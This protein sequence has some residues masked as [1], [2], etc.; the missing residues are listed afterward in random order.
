[1][2]SNETAS[3]FYHRL[4]E[5]FKH[6]YGHRLKFGDHHFT[7]MSK[8]DFY[9][10]KF[11]IFESEKVFFI[12]SITKII[13]NLKSEKYIEE[14]RRKISDEKTFSSPFYGTGMLDEDHGTCKVF[15]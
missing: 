15:F 12:S 10:F 5:S 1:M 8:V 13:N 11:P 9:L 2:T 7:D 4:S 14:I 3:L 6:A